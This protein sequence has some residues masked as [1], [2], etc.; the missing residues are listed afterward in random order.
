LDFEPAL[1]Q[2]LRHLHAEQA[3][4]LP[5]LSWQSPGS[6]ENLFLTENVKRS[7]GAAHQSGAS[8]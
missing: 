8:I 2:T 3:H 6:T 1:F 5:T 7:D 4:K